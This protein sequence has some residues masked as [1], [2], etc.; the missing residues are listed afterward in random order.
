MSAGEWFHLARIHFLPAR[1]ARLHTHDFPEVFWIESGEGWHMINRAEKKLRSGDLLFVRMKDEH[2]LRAAD[3][4]GFTLVNLAFPA[5]LLAELRAR[6]PE[7][8][9][10][11]PAR[12][13]LPVRC[14]LS[15]V[16]VRQLADEVRRLAAGGRRRMSVERF[17]LGLY[18][19][20]MPAG[21]NPV[22][23]LPAWL[24]R[25]TA[26]LERPEHFVAGTRALA[27]L[28]GRSAEHVART[29]RQQLHLSPTEL[30]NRVRMEH[31]AR[32]LRLGSK[33]I[34]EIALEC[35]CNNLAHFYSLFRAAHG[36]TPR[37]YRLACQ[38]ALG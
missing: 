9:T 19:M 6:Y 26:E 18:L 2:V 8:A 38:Q 33:P 37:R 5:R 22:P 31:A 20:A 25:A 35:G 32:E 4:R 10:L 21:E 30:V 23:A 29:C 12:T 3:E 16:Q 17:L 36:E 27:K 7:L 14:T 1:P 15:A 34:V 13:K 11:Y 24:L 28:A